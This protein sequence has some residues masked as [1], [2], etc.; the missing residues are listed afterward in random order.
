[1]SPVLSKQATP[2]V[3]D[4]TTVQ[5]PTGGLNSIS[6]VSNMPAEDAVVLR[7]LIPQPYGA[8]MRNG[9][10]K[11]SVLPANVAAETIM[12]YASKIGVETLFSVGNN[13][14][15]YNSTTAGNAVATA[16]TG[17]LN[18]RFQYLTFS[19]AAGNFLLAAN[20]QD[21]WIKYDGATITRVA[22]ADITGVDPKSIISLEVHQRRLWM[23]QVN[24][25]K[26]WYL[27]PDAISGA[28]TAFDFGPL[29]KRGG[30]LMT[31]VAWTIDTGEGSDDRLCAISSHGEVAVYN[32]TDPANIATWQLQG[33][34]F[35]GPPVGRRCAKKI[36]GDINIITQYGLT[37]LAEAVVSTKLN[38]QSA[39]IALKVQN[40]LSTG[41]ARFGTNFGWEI[42]LNPRDNLLVINTPIQMAD[43]SEVSAYALSSS[44]R[45]NQVVMNTITNNWCTFTEVPAFTW[46]TFLS[47]PYFGATGF[48]GRGMVGNQ[49]AVQN[50]G[51]GG[52]PIV[53]EVL[54]AF[55]YFGQPGREK[56]FSMVRPVFIAT[57]DLTWSAQ[58]RTDF[59]TRPIDPPNY[60]SPIAGNGVWDVSL[61]DAAL[62]AG[63]LA[64]IQR[65]VSASGLGFAGTIAMSLTSSSDVTWTS[66]DWLFQPGGIF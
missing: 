16:V 25:T 23:V 8:K 36:S 32:G 45:S 30:Y 54:Q 65:W 56:Y 49:D 50:D 19:N 29:F 37:S 57:G 66:T 28:A 38:N 11:H 48:V 10:V 58:V 40:L 18:A 26:G 43:V 55:N 52:Q 1:M 14:I 34:Y 12:P 61:W 17:L 44:M 24:T 33:V 5:A 22:A 46:A 6:A 60:T 4:T 27:A 3:S 42:H 47:A 62:W 64:T 7:N 20:G 35:V 39:G 21:D 31:L 15:L 63:G 53:G 51:L 13:G 9:Y 2:R 41:I 59:D